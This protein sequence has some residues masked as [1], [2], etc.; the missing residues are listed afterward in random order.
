MSA[1]EVAAIP[2]AECITNGAI[3]PATNPLA[4]DPTKACREDAMPRRCG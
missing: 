1:N 3:T 4:V 2:I